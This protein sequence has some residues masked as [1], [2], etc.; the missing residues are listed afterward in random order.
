MLDLLGIEPP[1]MLKGVPQERMAGSSFRGT[2]D[3]GGAPDTRTVQY[4]ELYSSRAIYADGW[5]A[6][7]FHA[8]PGLPADGPGD[9]NLPFSDDVWELYYVAEDFAENHNLAAQE[10]RGSCNRQG[11]PLSRHG[12]SLEG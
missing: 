1:A 10:P 2:L 4:Y 6:V 12:G 7:T 11:A 8:A 9:L 3:D 5:K